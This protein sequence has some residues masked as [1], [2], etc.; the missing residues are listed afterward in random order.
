MRALS[1]INVQKSN[2]NPDDHIRAL[3]ERFRSDIETLDAAF[4]DAMSG[5]SR[6]LWE[7]KFWGGSDQAIIGYGDYTYEKSNQEVV[8]WFIVGLAAQKDYISVYVNAVEDGQ[9]LPVKYSDRLGRARIGR[10]SV[11][12]SKLADIDLEALVE[13]VERA[14]LLMT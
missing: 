11:S 12:F 2:L 6:D 3:P 9:Y 5:L 1:E 8:H 4:T 14:R 13:L 10:A 7:G